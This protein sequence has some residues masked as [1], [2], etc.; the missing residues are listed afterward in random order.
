MKYPEYC[1]KMN[2]SD[3]VLDKFWSKV[4]IPEDYENDCW[5][6][7][8]GLNNFGYGCFSIKRIHFNTHRFAYQCYYGEISSSDQLCMHSCNN[9]PC[10]NPNHLSLGT[11]KDNANYMVSSGRFVPNTTRPYIP[12]KNI[13]RI[14]LTDAELVK[15]FDGIKSGEYWNSKQILDKYMI[16]W[17]TFHKIMSGKL[18]CHITRKYNLIEL[19]DK[20]MDSKNLVNR[21]M[22]ENIKKD[23]KSGLMNVEIIEK[24]DISKSNFYY[25]KEKGLI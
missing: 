12:E 17:S 16:T 19:K 20:I 25:L 13:V 22:L 4:D 2:Y 14:V 5:I 7:K 18:R 21:K 11:A 10:V 6:W 1:N 23:L 3:H 8:G 24:Y 15:V 9:P